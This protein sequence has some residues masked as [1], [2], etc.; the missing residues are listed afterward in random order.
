MSERLRLF[1]AC[2][3]SEELKGALSRIQVALRQQALEGLRW[4]RP[5]AIHLTLKF[6]GETAAEKAPSIQEAV[7]GCCIGIPPFE[8]KLGDLGTFGNRQGPR[9]IWVGLAGELEV[10]VELQRRL[11]GAMAG[12]GFPPEKRPFSPHLT[13]A[14]VPEGTLVSQRQRILEALPKV[15]V[16][17]ISQRV[18]EVSLMRSLL[19]PSGAVYQRLATFP[20]AIE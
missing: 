11:E 6:L 4:V 20:L 19:Q 5:E 14:R 17:T 9:V 1:V 3:L 7:A 13:L 2:E 12:L 16:P 10:M 8:L 18:S 15:V